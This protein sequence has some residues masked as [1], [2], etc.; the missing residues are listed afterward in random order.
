M[1]LIYLGVGLSRTG[2]TSL[3]AAMTNLGFRSLHWEPQRLRAVVHGAES[4]PSFR[5]YDD[6]DC[7]FD[8]PHAYFFKEIGAA[9]RGLKYILTV[10]NE[11]DWFRSIVRHYA[12]LPD[13]FSPHEL[14]E[15][16]ELQKLV[17][18]S[19]SFPELDG[20]YRLPPFLYK[21]K[22][23]D[24]NDHVRASI[25]PQDLLEIDVCAGQGWESLCP[26]V[27]RPLPDMPFPHENGTNW[28]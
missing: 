2:T 10:R 11:D 3:H 24:W 8:V 14:W 5:Y 23:R 25:A 18:G 15:A 4:N 12:S 28:F 22:F 27:G 20:F 26:F 17:Y 6:C 9:Y 1:P 13:S 16:S 7:I 21:K 19:G